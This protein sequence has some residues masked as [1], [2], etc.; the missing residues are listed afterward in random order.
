MDLCCDVGLFILN[1]RTPRDESRE[2]T[3]LANG[4]HNTID[5]IIGSFVIWQVTTH[6]EV[7]IDDI[8]YCVIGGDSDHMPLRLRLSINCSF[9]EPQHTIVTNFFWPRFK[10]DK[11]KA[12]KYQ[13]VVTTS[14]GNLWVVN[15]IGYLGAD[16]L[17]DLL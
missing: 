6:F 16:R 14:L 10:Y 8:C 15:S 1:G 5:Y 2:F 3:W 11:S 4:G 13:L 9:V 7:I 17:T 12:K